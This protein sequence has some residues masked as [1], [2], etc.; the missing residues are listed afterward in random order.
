MKFD[1]YLD[2][3]EIYNAIERAEGTEDLQIVLQCDLDAKTKKVKVLR[4]QLYGVCT[5]EYLADF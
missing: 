4:R 3:D 1:L 2:A 5:T